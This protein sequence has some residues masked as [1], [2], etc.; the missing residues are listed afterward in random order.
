MKLIAATHIILLA[1][2]ATIA[3][4]EEEPSQ[5][6]ISADFLSVPTAV[7]DKLNRQSPDETPTVKVLL[8]LKRSGKAISLAS[9]MLLT[10]SGQE[11]ISKSVTEVIYPTTLSFCQGAAT[12]M[13]TE[14]LSS[15]LV[16]P[17]D[18][19]TRE[20]G[21]TLS[22]LTEL[23]PEGDLMR[24]MIDAKIVD[25]PTWKDYP[26]EFQ[27]SKGKTKSTTLSM[28]FF[29]VRQF[30]TSV[31]IKNG[32]TIV[33]GGGIKNSKGDAVT[34]LL[35]KAQR[36]TSRGEAASHISKASQ[37]AWSPPNRKFKSEQEW[38]HFKQGQLAAIAIFEDLG[39][40]PINDSSIS[41]ENH[42]A[43]YPDTHT[44]ILFP[45]DSWII[46]TAH[47]CH[48]YEE[49]LGDI[50]LGLTSSGKFYLN[51]GHVC[52]GLSFESKK[53]VKSLSDFLETTGM[54]PKMEPIP[55]QEHLVDGKGSAPPTPNTISEAPKK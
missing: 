51:R 41:S 7:I 5:I 20:V 24:T 22:V 13:S 30:N 16:T 23:S 2:I 37:K 33:A 55:W 39:R 31:L 21:I 28:P 54:G 8:D 42:Q 25:P 29:H 44:R 49:G 26:S 10:G 38:L 19:E 11:A 17:E 46:L 48:Y 6:Y 3:S 50:I 36:V 40:I 45:D 35:L 53:E 47:S 18:F 43:Y 32:A 14:A 4:A 15:S 27:N 12:N 52:G 1:L 34:F 9:P